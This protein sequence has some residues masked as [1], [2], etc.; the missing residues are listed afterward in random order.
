MDSTDTIA[1]SF[2]NSSRKTLRYIPPIFQREEIVIKP[3][4][5]MVEN[6]SRRWHSTAVGYFLGRRPYF[7]QLEAFARANWEEL[8]Q[9]SATSNGF[10]FF[11]FK[12]LAFMEEVIEEGPWL[13][14]GQPVVLQPWE[15]GMSLRRQKHLRVP[16]WI[17]LRHLPME[18]W[19]EDGLS[20]VASG[21]GTPLYTDK[22]TK[23]CLRLDFARVCIML[24][25]CSKLPKHVI[26]L[27]PIL[28][29]G[30][31]VPIKVDIEYEWLPLRCTHCCSLGHAAKGYPE[32]K[33]SRP[34]VPVTVYV[35]KS[36]STKSTVGA[37]DHVDVDAP[38]AQVEVS[39]DRC[40]NWSDDIRGG[41]VGTPS[42][43]HLRNIKLPPDPE[44]NKSLPLSTKAVW[45][46]RGLNSVAHQHA[47]GH[48]VREKGIQ[49]LG[50][51][52]TRVRRGNIQSVRAGLLP[53]WSWF[54]DYTEPGG[55]IW[56]AW[57][58]VEIGVEVLL[59]AGQFI[60]CRLLNKR[61]STTC[62]TTVV[63]GECDLVRRRLLWEELRNISAAT[64]DVPWCVLGDF[65]IVVDASESC[66]RTAEST[67]AMAEFREF[68]G[69]AALVHL[70]FTG[71][72]FTWHNCSEG[73]R[74]LWRRLDRILVN[75]AW[76]E[77]W[78][79]SSYLSALPQTSDHSP[80]VL[81][82]APRPQGGIFRFDNFLSSQPGF[83]N[84]VRQV[85]SHSIYG[86]HM[87]AIT[88]KLKALKPIF[89]AQRKLKWC[90]TVYCRAIAMEDSMLRQRA[91]LQWYKYGDR[92]SKVF[93]RK[94][95]ATRVKMRVYQISNAAGVT[96]TTEDQVAAEFVGYYEGLLGGVRSQRSLNLDFLQPYLKHTLSVEEANELIQPVSASEIQE[97]FFDIS[98]DSARG[99]MG[100]LLKQLNAT[101][102][103]LIPKVQLPTRVAEFRPIACCN[104]LYNA[105]SKILVRRM[106]QVLDKLIDYSQNAFVPGRSIADNVLLAQELLAGYN[107]ARLPK[108]C[109]IKIDIQK[110]YDSVSW[111]FLLASL[112][113]FQ[114]P[115]QFIVWIEQCIS[116]ATFSI[117]LNG[118]LHGFFKGSRGIRQGDP[119]SP[120]LFVLVMEM[121]HV[122][123]HLRVQPEG[124]FRFH[125]KC[126]ELQILN[127]CFAD[128]V[129][130]FCAGDVPSVSTIIQVLEEF[131]ALSGLHVN[132]GKSTI[133]LSRSVQRE[134]QDILN[135]AGFQEGCL[136]IK[137]LGVPLT[138]SRLTVADCQP[139]L[140]RM[141]S[142]LARWAHLS[143]SM[144][145]RAQLLES[146]LGSLHIYWSSVFILPKSIIK[147][148]EQY[149]R[150]FLWKGASG[151]GLVNVSWDQV[152]KPKE[153]GGL[154]IRRVLHMNQALILRHVWRILQEDPNSIW[155]AWVLRYM[156]RNHTIWTV[157]T[158]SASWC[159]KKLVKV[160]WL[161]REGL[162]YRVGDGCKFR[163]W[164]DLW[165][166]EGP[167]IH[168][169]PRGPTITGLPA[170]SRLILVIHQGQWCWPSQTDFDIQQ[171]MAELPSIYSQRHD[172]ISWKPGGK[173]CLSRHVFILWLAI[174]E[175]LSTM[176]R[177]WAA[178]TGQGC[179]LCGG[180]A[181]GITQTPI[182]SVFLHEVLLGNAEASSSFPMA[183]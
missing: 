165:H 37:K 33:V 78:P 142:Q 111:E 63:Y 21:I 156:L 92:C 3:T 110:A 102:L 154:G 148:I 98:V 169:F 38:C 42:A 140:D 163:L 112:K 146:V 44:L 50:L 166:P 182:F 179:V 124:V 100:S 176:D 58:A 60:H 66:G 158:A 39:E 68:I 40:P 135:L 69:D 47:V 83:I 93:F 133:I 77:V 72:P 157:N 45:N 147:V 36:Q 14:Q 151:S 81:M 18:Y 168:K 79:L 141:S 12:M 23:N 30:K 35:Q 73:N 136:P 56:L 54:D 174:L 89:R 119:I 59:V 26:V 1:E 84:S 19:T 155:V 173:F 41:H 25:Y 6:G 126:S 67:P 48:L 43:T 118:Q 109:T 71:C 101:L 177:I 129:L 5:A 183:E 143:L 164:T 85:W 125:W 134:R 64:A 52:E 181:N 95:N 10:F 115:R 160:S 62:L 149:M 127:L 152:C 159:W 31:E 13:F 15:Q 2:L 53:S 104:V 132:P 170:D 180:A 74:S 161:L 24:D 27:S 34:K 70:P 49:F 178:S 123:L 175:R 11:R 51:L 121:L 107:Q 122:L 97:A 86:T 150:T 144:A 105:I 20:A 130:L 99:P 17:R 9:V 138:A 137:Y 29:E 61:T 87:Y 114:F 65:N 88:R 57:N 94:I 171:I 8:L 103:V 46:V 76:V 91:K 32:L 55:Q 22:I 139:I 167:L 113:V 162:D 90:R 145:G 96:L 128:D 28:A 80:L 117:A 4:P 172:E 75:D 116:T 7:P 16:V 106:Q 108:R 120:Y 131:A 82:G 153:E